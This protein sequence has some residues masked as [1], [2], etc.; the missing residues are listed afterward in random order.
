[1]FHIN[2]L[3]SKYLDVCA[4]QEKYNLSHQSM[5]VIES[6]QAEEFSEFTFANNFI[7]R[8]DGAVDFLYVYLGALQQGYIAPFPKVIALFIQ[9]HPVRFD[10][11]W[12]FVQKANMSKGNGGVPVYNE[13]GKLMKGD[14]FMPPEHFAQ[15]TLIG[16]AML[17]I[18]NDVNPR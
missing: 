4:F 6:N 13:E 3:K 9:N 11:W 7:E 2:N 1:M 5:N 15:A 16:Q 8:M 18:K 10:H 12:S 14:D 17:K